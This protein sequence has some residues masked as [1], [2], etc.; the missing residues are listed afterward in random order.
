MLEITDPGETPAQT[1]GQKRR[2]LRESLNSFLVSART[3]LSQ[4]RPNAPSLDTVNNFNP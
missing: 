1:S 4:G 3:E 2:L